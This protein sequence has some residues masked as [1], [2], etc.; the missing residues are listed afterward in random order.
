MSCSCLSYADAFE[1]SN[2]FGGLREINGGYYQSPAKI[3]PLR[4]AMGDIVPDPTASE[5]NIFLEGI[6]MLGKRILAEG[7]SGKGVDTYD[8]QAEL[9]RDPNCFEQAEKLL[10]STDN[11]YANVYSANSSK[12]FDIDIVRFHPYKLDSGETIPQAINLHQ[13]IDHCKTS[14]LPPKTSYVG[15]CTPFMGGYYA[16]YKLLHRTDKPC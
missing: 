13:Y 16:V 3:P 9:Y 12:A 10:L 2:P 15:Q 8:L 4:N 11:C 7:N 1:V 6:G 14:N 5:G